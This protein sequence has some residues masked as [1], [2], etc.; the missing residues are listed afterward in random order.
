MHE[1]GINKESANSTDYKFASHLPSK[2]TFS[3][4][5]LFFV[6]IAS[7]FYLNSVQAKPGF[8][9]VDL[10]EEPIEAA[11]LTRNSRQIIETI[12]LGI[13]AGQAIAGGVGSALNSPSCTRFGCHK[14]YCWAYCHAVLGNE[15]EWC[16]TTR[17]SSQDYNYVGCSRDS[18]CD[19]CWKCAGA[20]SIG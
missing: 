12:G 18:D 11:N 17:G 10:I 2:M 19:G 9:E 16:Y 1:F 5:I 3:S 6:L 14:G 7:V 13:A 20:C 4:A 8:G 15:R